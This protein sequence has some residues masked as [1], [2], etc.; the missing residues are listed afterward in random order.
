MNKTIFLGD[1]GFTSSALNSYQ[2][3]KKNMVKEIYAA[4][5]QFARDKLQHSISPAIQMLPAKEIIHLTSAADDY[6]M[7]QISE[8]SPLVNHYFEPANPNAKSLYRCYVA[9]EVDNILLQ[10]LATQLTHRWSETI[11]TNERTINEN[12]ANI[13]NSK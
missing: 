2:L 9:G 6:V 12:I 5:L 1:S 11:L 10:D 4:V 13:A 7:Y 3:A 8:N